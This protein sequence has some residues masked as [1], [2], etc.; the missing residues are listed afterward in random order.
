MNLFG[1]ALKYSQYKTKSK[2]EVGYYKKINQIVYYLKDNGVGF[3]MEYHDKIFGVFQRLHS[4]EEFQGTGI[5]LA[6]VQK[7]IQR[8][9]GNVWAESILD[10]GSSFYFNLPE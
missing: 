2:I 6:I 9:N 4:Q 7:I 3:E 10:E 1:N 8:H 5:G